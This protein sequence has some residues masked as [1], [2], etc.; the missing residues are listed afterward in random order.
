MLNS[1]YVDYYI[2]GTTLG[3]VRAR[4]AE[5]EAGQLDEAKA[6]YRSALGIME[7]LQGPQDLLQDRCLTLT[8]PLN[9]PPG[10]WSGLRERFGGGAMVPGWGWIRIARR[11]ARLR[12]QGALPPRRILDAL[13]GLQGLAAVRLGTRAL[14]GIV[15]AVDRRVA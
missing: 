14:V 3:L 12:R 2:I 7:A 4:Q 13:P 5:R 9:R 10:V 8:L 11:I 6:F 1:L 15:V